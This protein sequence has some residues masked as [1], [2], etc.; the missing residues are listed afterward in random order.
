MAA[1]IEVEHLQGDEFRVTVREGGRRTVHT[2]TVA[3][4]YA[5]RLAGDSVS[6]ED[7]V[8]RSFEF[9]LEHEPK[10]SILGSFDLSVISRYFPGYEA[11]I[12]RRLRGA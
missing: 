6:R 11:E 7:L 2:V 12:G 8:R 1:R 10:E 3:Q 5:R 9:L 4:P